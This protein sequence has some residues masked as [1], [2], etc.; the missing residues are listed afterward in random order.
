MRELI[1]FRHAK[2]E[3][4][5][6]GGDRDRVL[7]ASGRET[8]AKMGL[9]LADAGVKPDLALVSK[10]ARTTETWNL[11]SAAFPRLRCEIRNDLYDASADD[12]AAAVNAASALAEVIVVVGHNPGLQSYAVELLGRSGAAPSA[13]ARVAASFRPATAAVIRHRR[14]RARDARRLLRSTRL[15][16]GMT[17]RSGFAA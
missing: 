10:S 7:A 9:K 11:A 12:L 6:T 14:R 4:T 15:E 2:A 5:S 8:A 13:I 3:P 1:L 16:R 17:G